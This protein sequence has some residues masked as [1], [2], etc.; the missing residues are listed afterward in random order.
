M[1]KPI[2]QI[3]IIFGASGDLT[4]RKLVPALFELYLQN[5]LPKKFAVLGVSRT[6]LSDENFR[7]NMDEFLPASDEAK[8]FKKLLY[9][10]PLSVTNSGEYQQFKHRLEKIGTENNIP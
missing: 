8:T 6:N 3:L 10:Q 9:Y 1:K 5:L 2:N 4:K 7:N